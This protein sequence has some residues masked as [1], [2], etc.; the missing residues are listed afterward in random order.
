M[1]WKESESCIQSSQTVVFGFNEYHVSSFDYLKITYTHL[2]ISNLLILNF[3]YFSHFFYL[4]KIQR[5]CIVYLSAN[6]ILKDAP[7]N[8]HYRECG[9]CV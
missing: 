1:L 7:A 9:L 2:Q 3:T 5:I 8:I 6:S 4:T